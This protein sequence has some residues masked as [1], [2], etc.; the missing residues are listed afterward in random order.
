MNRRNDT[1]SEKIDRNTLCHC[2][3]GKKYKKCCLNAPAGAKIFSNGSEVADLSWRKLRQ[4]EGKVLDDH[5]IP[6]ATD[7]LPPDIVEYAHDDIMFADLPEVI[8]KELFVS[9]FFM[10]WLL[11]NWH[12]MDNVGIA[13]FE[14]ALTIA[15]NYVRLYATRL[16]SKERAFID[17]MAGTYYSFYRIEDVVLDKSLQVKDILLD[18]THTV[19][20]YQ[21][22]HHLKPGDIVFS[23]ILT[24]DN[25]SIFVGMMPLRLPP[26]CYHLLLE[27]KSWLLE[28]NDQTPLTPDFLHN[29]AAST[30]LDYFFDLLELLST[31]P[32][33][34]NNEGH[35]LQFTK[36]YFAFTQSIEETLQQLLPAFTEQTA[37]DILEHAQYSPEG[38]LRHIE[39]A[40][41][42][43]QDDGDTT[44]RFMGEGLTVMGYIALEPNR[45]ILTTHSEERTEQGKLMLSQCLGED[46][47]F[48]VSRI[49]NFAHDSLKE[50]S[51]YTDS[52]E[53]TPEMQEHIQALA[54][55][56]W[57]HWMDDPIPLLDNQT[58]RQA[59]KTSRGREL[60]QALLLEYEEHNHNM[61][62]N[63]LKADIN[64]LKKKLALDK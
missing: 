56:H 46:I 23:R 42:Q 41:L 47:T 10:P 28:D 7:V 38:E 19:K 2:G 55:K 54:N 18:A 40:W 35:T 59:A 58:P 11:F 21:G 1:M 12:L 30:C 6:Y 20:E 34:V 3:S 5:L 15:E 51:S 14:P 33:L 53:L 44:P 17:A 9:N 27:L 64:A 8:D 60:L 4:L 62:N 57:E 29:D 43:S 48:Q 16:N 32:V 49:D 13:D 22:T 52:T 31:P 63:L 36:S 25:Q 24:M 50:P 39:F 45:L 37:A 61:P 26:R